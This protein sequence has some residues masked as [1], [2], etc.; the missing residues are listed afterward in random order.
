MI[1]LAAVPADAAGGGLEA[2][3]SGTRPAA[4]VGVRLTA[5]SGRHQAA[6]PRA[7]LVMAPM[8]YRRADSGTIDRSRIGEGL[9][10]NFTGS[11]K[12][13]LTLAGMRAD[14]IG[15]FATRSTRHS[16][17]RSNLSTGGWIAVGVGT[18]AVLAIGLYAF[19]EHVEYCE[20]ED[21]EC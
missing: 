14:R 10:L 5:S 18:V 9:A 1:A 7:S 15:A 2:A 12:P 6:T 21:H 11:G 4:F 8:S 3:A 20:E 19:A 13:S 17:A 16:G